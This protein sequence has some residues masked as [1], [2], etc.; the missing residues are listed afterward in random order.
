MNLLKKASDEVSFFLFLDCNMNV[1]ISF[2]DKQDY[3]L[4]KDRHYTMKF[5]RFLFVSL[6]I[7]F[8]LAGSCVV[9]AFK[10]E[11]YRITSN[12]YYLNQETEDSIKIVQFSDIHIKEDFTYKNLEKVVNTINEQNPDVVVFTGDLY[13]NYAKYNDDK[14]IVRELQKIQANYDKIAIW[15]NRDYGGGA[16]RQYENIMEQA[17]FT[18]LKNENWY[19]T[20]DTNKK[21]LFTG[22]DDSLLGNVY[23][24]DDTKIYNSDYDIL[25][26]HEPDMADIF[27]E[28][29]YDL[30]LSG[31]SHGGQVNIPFIPIINQMAVSAT[32]LASKYTGGMFQLG[33]YTNMYV[34]T[35][36]GTT[37]ISARFG[38]PPEI[39]VFTIY[40]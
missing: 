7:M 38:V 10:I 8:L 30:V 32:S 36:I 17:E 4:R 39:S 21:V 5:L 11:P 13:D 33:T 15:G 26:T 28:Y 37:H 2:Y 22:V 23:M 24:P 34:N 27:Q 9:Y 31:H 35:G 1:T 29:N 19:I 6:L 16:V 18:V 14:K 12:K 25:L 20:T 3:C 40:L